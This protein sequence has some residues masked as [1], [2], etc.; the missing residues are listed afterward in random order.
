MTAPALFGYQE[1]AADAL[2]KA[3][4]THHYALD[5]SD[6]GTGKTVVA[7][8]VARRLGLRPFVICPKAVIPAWKRWMTAF[9]LDQPFAINFEKLRYGN[10]P[11]VTKTGEGRGV[12][13]RLPPRSLVIVDEAHRASGMESWNAYMVGYLRAYQIP[14]AILSATLAESPLKMRAPGYLLGL[15]KWKDYPNWLREN[16]CYRDN[17]LRWRFT[18]GP[19]ATEILTR[20]H[21]HIFP[22]RG[23]RISIADLGDAFPDCSNFAEA[24][25]TGQAD[26]INH[27]YLDFEMVDD[28]ATGGKRQMTGLEAM[29]RGR[30]AAEKAK[31][32]MLI[33]MTQDLVDENNSVVVAFNFRESFG[34]F[35]EAFPDCAWIR[36]DQS[37][38]TRE[39]QIRR[40]QMDEA[41]VI[42][43]MIQAGGVGIS[44]HDTIGRYPRVALICPTWSAVELKQMLGRI[45]RAGAKSKAINRIIFAA[46]TIEETACESAKRKLT[47]MQLLND[48]DLSA[49]LPYTL[50]TEV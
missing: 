18:T 31:V 17:A 32:P 10:T 5:A 39:E 9:N 47:N 12:V 2:F 11:F 3:L 50:T 27:A 36:G 22:E 49:G 21:T 43:V 23:A 30:Q 44:L 14:T 28:L 15:H 24:Y 1:P 48:G 38:R 46:D 6:T 33:E 26:K 8:E 35:C 40:F 42:A 45:H 13:W 16:G 25:D 29:L 20:I 19:A 4:Q 7:C 37:S 34:T 41:R